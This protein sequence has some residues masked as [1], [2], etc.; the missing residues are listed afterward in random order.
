M[1]AWRFTFHLPRKK[2]RILSSDAVPGL[3][4]AMLARL[5]ANPTDDVSKASRSPGADFHTYT[6]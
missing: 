5:R 2:L 3:I 6:P 4:K 1:L